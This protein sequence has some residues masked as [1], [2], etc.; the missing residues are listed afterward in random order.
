MVN[1]QIEGKQVRLG[2]FDIGSEIQAAKCYDM[3]KIKNRSFVGLNFHHYKELQED[4]SIAAVAAIAA[5]TIAPVVGSTS[6]PTSKFVGT[7]YEFRRRGSNKWYSRIQVEGVA[8]YLGYYNNEEDVARAYGLAKRSLAQ[9]PEHSEPT[10]LL[11]YMTKEDNFEN[12][13]TV[14]SRYTRDVL[15]RTNVP[16]YQ[17]YYDHHHYYDI[18]LYC[19]AYIT[20]STAHCPNLL[21]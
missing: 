9:I 13:L 1:L 3:A 2:K 4:T 12:L 14:R 20:L 5:A 7:Y 17:H 15:V 6:K 18:L 19:C 8:K 16:F 21:K 10:D 11:S